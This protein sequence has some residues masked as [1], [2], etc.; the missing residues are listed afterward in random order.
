MSYEHSENILIQGAAGGAGTDLT[1]G[2]NFH[3]S[4]DVR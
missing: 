1:V 4:Y 2:V 3:R